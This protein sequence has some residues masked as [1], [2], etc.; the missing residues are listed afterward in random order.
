M[1]VLNE[2]LEL[3]SL[4]PNDRFAFGGTPRR[5]LFR[6]SEHLLRFVSLCGP[7]PTFTGGN[8]LFDSPWWYPQSTFNS[9]VR[10][11]NRTGKSI[12]DVARSGLAVTTQ[13]NPTMEYLV[14]IE[15]KAPI[16]GLVGPARHQPLNQG[17]RST[18]L[19]GNLEQAYIPGLSGDANGLS[20]P[21]AF[22][23]SYTDMTTV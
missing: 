12:V 3:S 19:I 22:I 20:S 18:L 6:E 16:Y 4:D 11:S 21:Y 7:A 5:R 13:W 15:L 2:N 8:K 1:D 23:Y 10:R 14:T 9:I 17:D